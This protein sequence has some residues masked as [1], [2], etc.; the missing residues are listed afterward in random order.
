MCTA[1]APL[2][3]SAQHALLF[4]SAPRL[5]LHSHRHCTLPVCCCHHCAQ[6][7]G[8]HC[9]VRPALLPRAAHSA[10]G[11]PP[12]TVRSRPAHSLHSVASSCHPGQRHVSRRHRPLRWRSPSLCHLCGLHLWL[13]ASG[14]AAVAP[15]TC[16]PR[17]LLLRR[18]VPHQRSRVH[19]RDSR[20]DRRRRRHT[21][22]AA[23]LCAKWPALRLRA[24][25]RATQPPSTVSS[26]SR[27]LRVPRSVA[28]AD[29]PLRRC[30]SHHR[31]PPRRKQ[32]L[33]LRGCHDPLLAAVRAPPRT[34]PARVPRP[35][36]WR[37][38]RLRRAHQQRAT[39]MR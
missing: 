3:P 1:L 14:S 17:V 25:R 2:Q 34:Y 7:A 22:H 24:A 12:V 9:S 13:L 30:A 23:A 16:A 11:T 10:A 26:R 35:R 28:A 20:F 31:H 33:L 39:G 4:L 5:L 29:H 21:R 27:L 6:P 36:W 38:H 15:V 18:A 32:G 8:A 37:H 19:R